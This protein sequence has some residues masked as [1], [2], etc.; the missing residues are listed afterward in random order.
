M[1]V[2]TATILPRP[3]HFPRLLPRAPGIDPA[4]LPLQGK[5]YGRLNAS[6]NLS[7]E[8]DDLSDEENELEDMVS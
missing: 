5:T 6:R 1:S 2:A 7:R 4:P 3:L 8:M